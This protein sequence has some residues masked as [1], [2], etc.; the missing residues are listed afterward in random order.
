[1]SRPDLTPPRRPNGRRLFLRSAERAGRRRSAREIRAA[2]AF[3]NLRRSK[4]SRAGALGL[5]SWPPV[6]RCRAS[7][8]EDLNPVRSRDLPLCQLVPLRYRVPA[9]RPGF[10]ERDRGRDM[11]RQKE[12]VALLSGRARSTTHSTGPFARFSSGG[13]NSFHLAWLRWI[14]KLR[15]TDGITVVN[16]APRLRP[17]PTGW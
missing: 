8:S 12:T 9:G 11:P 17:W 14:V 1:M 2:A 7:Y 4:R 3:A 10:P 6:A 5:T 15:L 13:R 16:P